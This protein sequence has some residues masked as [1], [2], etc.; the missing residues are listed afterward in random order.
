MAQ[1]D[2]FVSWFDTPYY[3]ILYKHRNNTEA[4]AFMKNLVQKL[5]LNKEQLL[6]DLACGKG[7]H[8]I[9]LNLLGYNVTGAD[10]S[11]NN[12]AFAKKYENERLQFF[13]HDMRDSFST[14][15]DIILNLFTSFGFFE[16]DNDDILVLKN[17]KKGLNE[18]GLAV[19][20]FMNSNKVVN[21]LI[22]QE[23]VTIEGITFNISRYIK[24]GFI[25]KEINFIA[26]NES[27]TYY[28]KVKILPLEKIK[29]YLK[30]AGFS[31][32]YLFG[33]YDL[34]EFNK[35]ESDR[36]ILVLE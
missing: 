4:Q 26:D 6:L 10:L 19:V 18:G 31:I 8:A 22:Q 30:K 33:D 16:N 21:Q 24:D 14:K 29:S 7:R 15:Y 23:A 12:I 13:E 20:D 36:L 35:E 3:H 1:K 27:H 2:W 28:E 17:I 5:Q 34:N 9:F 11:K 25:V 32:K